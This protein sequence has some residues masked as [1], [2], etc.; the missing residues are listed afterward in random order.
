MFTSN[1]AMAVRQWNWVRQKKPSFFR[2]CL[3]V[4]QGKN[5][6]ENI[7][8]GLVILPSLKLTLHPPG[9]H[10]NRKFHFP[11][12]NFQ[13]ICWVFRGYCWCVCLNGSKTGGI[14]GVLFL[15]GSKENSDNENGGNKPP[16]QATADYPKQVNLYLKTCHGL[17]QC[18]FFSHP[19][20]KIRRMMS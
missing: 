7:N 16:P 3:G 18:I 12:I 11:T 4:N 14:V 10:P 19:R 1:H 8:W 13:W 5:T 15:S 2:L 17:Q 6:G 9:S 20:W